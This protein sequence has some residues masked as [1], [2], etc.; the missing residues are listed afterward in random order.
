[1]IGKNKIRIAEVIKINPLK[2]ILSPIKLDETAKL[3]FFN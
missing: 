1:M 3:R 2:I